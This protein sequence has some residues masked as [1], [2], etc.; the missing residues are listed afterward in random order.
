MTDYGGLPPEINSGRMYAGPGSAGLTESAAAWHALAGELGSVGVAYQAVVASLGAAGWQGPSS[1]SMATAAAPYVAWVLATAGQSEKAALA[2]Q[3]AAMVFESARAGVVPPAE[4]EANRDTLSTLIAT[5][6]LGVNTPAIA[7]TIA[8]YDEMWAQDATVLYGYSADAAGLS[9]GLAATPF[10]PPM[11]NTNLGGLAMQAA[12]VSQAGG[13]AAGNT[14]QTASQA[15]SQVSSMPAGMDAQSMLSMGPQL[16][17]MIPSA[18]Q[19]FSQPLMQP[20]SGLGQGFGQFQGLLSP[21]MGALSNPGLT[22]G[23]TGGASGAGSGVAGALSGGGGLA[24]GGGGAVTAAAGRAASVG[25]LSVPATWTAGGGQA[26]VGG[27]VTTAAASAAAPA[28]AAPATTSTGGGGAGMAPLAGMAGR[29]QGEGS[30]E[31]RY[32]SVVRVLR[33]PR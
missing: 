4:I 20:L 19:G 1:I 3:Q 21:F 33:D 18:L 16:M 30:G 24:S 27:S 10:T 2:A 5:N 13:N 8:A 25:G 28:G 7:A 15:G 23:L 31:P 26:P 9:G 11:P 6:F 32:G 22:G 12:S 17:G 29:G 14:A